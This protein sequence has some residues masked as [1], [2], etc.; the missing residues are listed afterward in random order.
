M[1]PDEILAH[2]LGI[3]L[4]PNAKPRAVPGRVNA[5]EQM[6]NGTGIPERVNALNSLLNPVTALGEAGGHSVNMLAPGRAPMQRVSDLG[7]MLTG[8]AGTVAPMVAASRG[9]VPAANALVDGL[10]GFNPTS[11]P[12]MFMAD[13]FGGV[14]VP[15]GGIT[16]YH[17]SKADFD[18]FSLDYAGTATDS[19]QLGRAVYVSTDPDVANFYPR[20]Y[21]VRANIQSPL[22]LEMPDWR[23]R[24]TKVIT[25]ALGLPRDAS[26]EE[27]AK[28]AMRQGYDSAVL[29]YS[30]AG[31]PQQE[32]AIFDDK[33]IEIVRKYGIAGAAAMLGV[34]AMD[35]EQAMAGQRE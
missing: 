29:D 16:A 34:S 2:Q 26:S 27:I 10:T 32:I 30:P 28:E 23:T 8:M 25:E 6:F 35:V 22:N 11:A 5:L 4:P 15:G 12:A 7:Q 17:G 1:T 18:A 33:L 24:K 20:K 13:E 9:A 31:Y 19:G 21:E 3:R 14:K